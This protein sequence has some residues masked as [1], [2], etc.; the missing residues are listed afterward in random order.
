MANTDMYKFQ[1]IEGI[2][3]AIDFKTKEEWDNKV[4]GIKRFRLFLYK[5]MLTSQHVAH[6]MLTNQQEEAQAWK[7]DLKILLD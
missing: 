2:I 4:G 3:K 6:I 1:V 5:N 7:K